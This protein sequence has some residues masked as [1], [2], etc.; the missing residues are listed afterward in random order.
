MGAYTSPRVLVVGV[1]NAY[2][3]D[4]AV[5]LIAARQIAAR[6]PSRSPGSGEGVPNIQVIEAS[7]EGTELIEA[8]QDAD[9]VVVIDAVHRERGA[10]PGTPHWFDAHEGSLPIHFFHTSTHAFGVAE[11]IELARALK[12][13][14]PQLIVYGI[15]GRV[16]EAG[17]GLSAELARAVPSVVTDVLGYIR[18]RMEERVPRTA[19]KPDSDNRGR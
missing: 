3:S 11:A 7:G 17:V 14:P 2:R 4:D 12:R 19:P 5:G 16:F 13:L 18:S 1:G 6:R 8:W 9:V 15:E 10:A